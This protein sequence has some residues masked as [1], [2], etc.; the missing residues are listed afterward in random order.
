M[1][2]ERMRDLTVVSWGE[3]LWD[4]FPEGRRLGGCAANVA[5]HLARL[6]I[7][8]QL[9]TRIG[10]DRLGAEAVSRLSALG[11]DVRFVQRDP[12]Q[13]TGTVRVEVVNG[14]PG[15]AIASEAAWDR[16][17][18]TEPVAQAVA[19]ADV[20]YYGTLAQRTP[21]GSGALA[22]AWSA[23]R[24][25]CLRVC[26]VNLRSP[27]PARDVV[28]A[29]LQAADAVKLN[30]RELAF[31]GETLGVAAPVGWLLRE[32]DVRLVA[33]T[34]G[35]RGCAL[36]REDTCVTHPG[37][38]L[39]DSDGDPVGAGDAFTAVL[40]DSL[41]RGEGFG[42]PDE[43]RRLAHRANRVASY[44]ASR[45]GATPRLPASLL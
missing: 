42:H 27:F 39:R 13:P 36:Y 37:F 6:G 26:D 33:V 1:T 35:N 18:W 7:E 22:R 44:V 28:A 3:V 24:P 38:P 15:F 14:E 2:E 23:T 41:A 5:V 16:I 40:C 45:P 29:S 32:Y 31:V 25:G 4:L 43:L 30:E 9:V 10:D 34:L 21:L 12:H 17:E 11:V 19:S 8:P 20:L